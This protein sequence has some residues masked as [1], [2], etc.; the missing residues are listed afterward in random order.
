[1]LVRRCVAVRGCSSCPAH[2][3]LHA[4]FPFLSTVTPRFVH[5]LVP[6]FCFCSVPCMS[7]A[8]CLCLS[9]ACPLGL[10]VLCFWS[11]PALSFAC[12]LLSRCL[13]DKPCPSCLVVSS[14]SLACCWSLALAALAV[15]IC[16]SSSLV[17]YG[18]PLVGW[19]FLPSL[20]HS[21]WGKG[22]TS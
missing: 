6:C 17:V 15:S 2:S 4:L 12:P 21:C 11:S 9:L 22:L 5:C 1:M 14:W 19:S 18:S 13:S 8:L 20:R 10:L 7:L 3:C 16:C